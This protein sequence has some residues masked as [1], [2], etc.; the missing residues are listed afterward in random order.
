LVEESRSTASA[1]A[2]VAETLD[3]YVITLPG[4]T[5]RFSGS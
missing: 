1:Y 5:N 3:K 2:H 4:V